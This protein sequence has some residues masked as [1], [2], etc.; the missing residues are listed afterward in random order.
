MKDKYMQDSLPGNNANNA[1]DLVYQFALAP[2]GWYA[3]CASG[4]YRSTDQG[5]SWSLAYE[6]LGATS[7][8]TTLSVAAAT[9]QDQAP[10]VFAGLSG[11]LLRS[12]DGGS[13][14]ELAPKPSPAPVF[15]ALV[16]SPDFT[17]DGKLFAATMEDGVLIYSNDGRE[18]AMWNFGM[19]DTNVLCLAVSPAYADDQ[20]L[21]AGVQSGLVRST[22]GGRSWHEIELPIGYAAVLCLALSPCFADDG[23]IFAGT[24][25][26]GLLHSADRGRSWQ[27]LGM[28]TWA[29]PINSIMLSPDFPAAPELLVLHGG[30]L[31]C[32]TDG[33][34]TWAPWRADRLAELDITAVLAPQGFGNDAPVLIGLA[35]GAIMLV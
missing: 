11:E 29:E 33:G 3:A 9:G 24:E 16:P 28:E 20:T 35:D 12:N 14:W 17:R 10:L 27:S 6:S 8:L 2:F 7:A 15:T 5:V 13:S 34:S 26:Y 18:W 23:V 31:L 25:E 30:S 19:L 21:F 22:N 1:N 4:L 32:S